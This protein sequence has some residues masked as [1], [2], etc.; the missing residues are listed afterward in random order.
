VGGT[1][2]VETDSGDGGTAGTKVGSNGF[3]LGEN[4]Q[5]RSNGATFVYQLAGAEYNIFTT[6]AS[7]QLYSWGISAANFEARRA[8]LNDSAFMI[9]AGGANGSYGPSTGWGNGVIFGEPSSGIAPVATTGTLIGTYLETLSNFTVTNE[10]DFSKVLCTGNA[11][12]STGALITCAGGGAF[13]GLSLNGTATYAIEFNNNGTA[14][15]FEA[16]AF[17]S[18]DWVPGSVANDIVFYNGANFDFTP[19]SGSSIAFQVQSSGGVSIGNTTNPGAGGIDVNGQI[20]APNMA[21]VSTTETG[22]V[23]WVTGSS[24]AGKLVEDSTACLS[25]RREW[26]HDEEPLADATAMLMRL[27]PKTFKWKEP[28]DANQRGE[29]IGMIAEDTLEADRRFASFDHDGE[30]HGWRQ[31]AVI[32]ALVKGFQEQQAQSVY[33]QARIGVLEHDLAGRQ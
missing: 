24:P 4:A 16:L 3:Y 7:S 15:A 28:K 17:N 8:T 2:I 5:A 23:C 21:G 25:S 27:Q 10:I 22:Y 6:S 29:Q 32:A 12:Q 14:K 18:S 11:W 26:K 20:Y 1:W 19:N 30:L 31:D 13:T 33:L 9:Y